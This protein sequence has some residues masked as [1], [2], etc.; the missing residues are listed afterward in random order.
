MNSI[1]ELG[2]I[3]IP[4]PLVDTEQNGTV[5]TGAYKMPL[6]QPSPE[7]R[8]E[9]VAMQVDLDS[10]TP[11]TGSEGFT[12]YFRLRH[13]QVEETQYSLVSES[14]V[15]ANGLGDDDAYLRDPNAG[16]RGF[17][18]SILVTSS[19]AFAISGYVDTSHGR[20][21]TTVEQSVS[22]LSRQNFEV[23]ATAD[24]QNAQQAT[25][26]DSLVRTRSGSEESVSE[27]HLSFPL[28]LNYSFV[29][30][31][32]GT[33]T[34]VTSTDQRDLERSTR[35]IGGR[36]GALDNHLQASDT[37]L[38]DAARH[39][40]ANS[41][42]RTTQRY[43]IADLTGSC[44]SRTLTAQAQKLVAVQDGEDCPSTRD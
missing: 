8:K 19:R 2:G 36:G 12:E 27:Q 11:L 43:R 23:S 20:V 44:S 7:A 29:A 1:N 26:V 16:D 22:F 25:R 31:P 41:G 18:G 5:E 4:M 13:G 21:L 32:D 35:G 38:F 40:V 34:Q 33:A 9:L 30:N 28:K 39:V 37:L 3:N 10:G 24:V 14:E 6:Y 42:S 15:A 17:T